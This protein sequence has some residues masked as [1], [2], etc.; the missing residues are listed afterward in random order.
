MPFSRNLRRHTFTYLRFFR[1][2]I[3]VIANELFIKKLQQKTAIKL[4]FRLTIIYLCYCDFQKNFKTIHQNPTAMK[5]RAITKRAT[6]AFFHLILM[7]S[8][9]SS[10]VYAQ[11]SAAI[12]IVPPDATAYEE[13]TLIFDPALACFQNGSLAGLPSIAIHSGVTFI[14]GETWQNVI[15]FN[16]NGVNGQPTTLYPTGDGRYSITYIPADFYG[17]TGQVV[18]HICAVFN[19]GTN[20]NQDGRDFLPGSWNC[21]DFFIPLNFENT[22]PEIHFNV[23]MTKM[24][25][26]ENF[27]PINDLVYLSFNQTFITQMTD[28]NQNAIYTVMLDEGIDVGQTYPYQY[29]INDNLYEAITREITVVAGAQN[30][31][32]WWNDEALGAITFVLDMNYQ[33]SLGNFNPLYDFVDVAGTF[34]E[35]QG[36][37]PMQE[38]GDNIYSVTL[39]V[40]PGLIEYKFRINGNWASSEF[41]DG[42]PN[43]MTWALTDP[44]TLYHF[45]DDYNPDTWPVFFEVDMN[46]EILEGNFN[47][48][49]DYL[50]I[51]GSMNGWGNHTILFDRD[52]TAVGVYTNKLLIDKYDPFIQFK[53]RINS[54]W[55][56]SEFPYGGPNRVMTAQDTTGGLVNLYTCIYNITDIP[57]PPYVY[58]LYIDGMLRVGQEVTGQYT[59]LDPNADPEGE[60]LYQWFISEDP[61]GINI[62]IIEDAESRDYLIQPEAYGKYLLFMILPVS[63]T[64]DP[65]TGYPQTTISGLVEGEIG[66]PEV[67]VPAIK[68]YPNPATDQINVSST[69]ILTRVEIFDIM[70]KKTVSLREINSKF[71]KLNLS[72]FDPGIYFLRYFDNEGGIGTLK[73]IKV[74]K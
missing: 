11:M 10:A 51:A 34:N 26:E 32:D 27:D 30:L 12:T 16:A 45:Y 35:W 67:N 14:S 28:D 70:G 46:S 74:S 44:I 73:L 56:T 62:T 54:N 5:P 8:V 40:D 9:I 37:E 58:N 64:G 71:L 1:Q 61:D 36:S 19:N 39:I 69:E 20:W 52:W 57:Y 49:T 29:R 59:F 17:L 25:A 55:E 50:D 7:L 13:M 21:M 18:T 53:F 23:N 68:F 2:R 60:S 41:P 6:K 42:G 4:A 72:H 43:R 65:S 3:E 33:V 31:S 24:I 63:A 38:T 15:N 48:A 47:P 66:I 22:L